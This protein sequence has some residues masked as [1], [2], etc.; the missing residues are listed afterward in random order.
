MINESPGN[1]GTGQPIAGALNVIKHGVEERFLRG[2][3]I[4]SHVLCLLGWHPSW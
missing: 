2:I 3:L 4:D 1:N